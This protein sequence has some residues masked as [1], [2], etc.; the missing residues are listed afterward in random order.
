VCCGMTDA[1][2]FGP[3]VCVL[4]TAHCVDNECAQ[5]QKVKGV[6]GTQGAE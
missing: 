6:Q 3:R 1:T 4:F 5:G 2:S